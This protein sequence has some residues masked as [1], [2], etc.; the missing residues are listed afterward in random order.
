MDRPTPSPS[1]AASQPEK[2]GPALAGICSEISTSAT[3]VA[4]SN[5][6]MTEPCTYREPPRGGSRAPLLEHPGTSWLKRKPQ[7][8]WPSGLF[9]ELK[10][11]CAAVSSSCRPGCATELISAPVHQAADSGPADMI[12]TMLPL[13][14]GDA[15]A[16]GMPRAPQLT[17]TLH[18][19]LGLRSES[20]PL[21]P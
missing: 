11:Q 12:C 14:A 2:Y 16:R 15:H 4:S 13:S 17:S 19:P 7:K 8:C 3:S 9:I 21:R 6:L 18:A 20:A 5:A 1:A 10:R